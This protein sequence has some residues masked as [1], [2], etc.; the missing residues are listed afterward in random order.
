[1]ATK[2]KTTLYKGL[3]LSKAKLTALA[4]L[5]GILGIYVVYQS[6]A[7]TATCTS[8]SFYSNAITYSFDKAYPCGQFA[9]GDWWVAP[10]TGESNV[11]ITGISPVFSGGQNGWEVNPSS[12]TQQGFDSDAPDYSIS[13]VPTPNTPTAGTPYIASA[14]QSIVKATSAPG[15]CGN[16]QGC[17]Q[18]AAVLTVLGAP[19]PDGTGA[20]YLRPPYVGT[21]KPLIPTT[22]LR[23][24]LLPKKS[25][26]GLSLPSINGAVSGNY[27]GLPRD[28]SR[29]QLDHSRGLA[30]RNLH[31]V[32]NLAD[33]GRDVGRQNNDAIGRLMFSDISINFSDSTVT[34]GEKL[35]VN[36][37][38]GGL[39]RYYMVPMGQTWIDGGPGHNPGRK[40]PILFATLMINDPTMI[41][42]VKTVPAYGNFHE[43]V[44]IQTGKNGVA[45][46]GGFDSNPG[47]AYYWDFI[48]STEPHN[49]DV[50]D[51]YGYIDGGTHNGGIDAYQY[52]CTSQVWKGEA[53]IVHL[54]P[55]L[56]NLWQNQAPFLNYVDRWVLQGAHYQPDPCAP[57]SQAGGPLSGNESPLDCVKDPDLNTLTSDPYDCQ[58]GKLCGRFPNLNASTC[59]APNSDGHGP[60]GDMTQYPE[61]SDDMWYAFVSQGH[62][63]AATAIPLPPTPTPPPP[64]PTPTPPPPSPTPTPPP[65]PPV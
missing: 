42:N 40:L 55:A 43:D 53:L 29:L 57:S 30:N 52:C 23:A 64:S 45:L 1:M 17:L 18:T 21:V 59:A 22:Q 2:S 41:N 8:A 13:Q 14:N 34:E 44:G 37:V 38:Q 12:A 48:S 25:T 47:E 5:G 60:N 10:N 16:S 46:W 27:D 65:P 7:A 3:K 15:G 56:Q 33:Y 62:C 39:D 36:T 28:F 6:L 31:P 35:L 50:A 19:P 24:D 58:A 11:R 9:N 4:I 54:M 32:Q 51:P 20:G 61:L 63:S 26:A 49:D